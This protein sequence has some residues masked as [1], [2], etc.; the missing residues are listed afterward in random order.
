[1]LTRL[2]S[3]LPVGELFGI[4]TPTNSVLCASIA[5]S[6][7]AIPGALSR[8]Y[9]TI[10]LAERLGTGFPFGTFVINLSGT[11]LIGFFATLANTAIFSSPNLQRLVIIGFLGSYTTFSTYAL[12][13]SILL[14][15]GSRVKSL[16]YGI[17]SIVLGGI[18][19]EIG[20][21]LAERLGN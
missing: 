8:Y 20:I 5:V 14:R 11:V 12:D 16:V 21:F 9:I 19:L 2:L 18:G 3:L 6:L 17:G 10:G 13:T 1:M 7:G 4:S 15:S